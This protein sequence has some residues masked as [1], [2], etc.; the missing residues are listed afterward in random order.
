MD[1]YNAVRAITL[2]PLLSATASPSLTVAA[3]AAAAA[4][5]S[6]R[7]QTNPFTPAYVEELL[8]PRLLFS[9]IPGVS[10][11]V[12]CLLCDA[13]RLRHE[14]QR[15]QRSAKAD[16]GSSVSNT[17]TSAS[18]APP[19]SPRSTLESQQAMEHDD[20]AAGVAPLP[21]PPAR[22]GDVLRCIARVF[23]ELLPSFSS[24]SAS[25]SPST[26]AAP[27]PLKRIAYLIERAA[28]SH[29][30]RYLLPHCA[31]ASEDTQHALQSVFDA[32]RC[33][34]TSTNSSSSASAAGSAGGDHGSRA[35]SASNASAATCNEMAQL[36]T[37]IL[38]ATRDISSAQ[39]TPLLEELAGA[40]CTLR[41]P[42][43]TSS[44]WSTVS[45]RGVGGN[46]GSSTAL[47]GVLAANNDVRGPTQLRGGALV[48]ARVLMEQADVV[49]QPAVAAWAVSEFN[50]GV[51]EL[52]AAG[53]LQEEADVEDDS[54]K[55]ERDDALKDQEDKNRPPPQQQRQQRTRDTQLSRRGRG[56]R[57]VARVLEVVVA[58]TELSVDLVS[59]VLP[60]IA[61]HLELPND[62]LRL[63]LVRGFG[64]VFAAHDAA[65]STYTSI[66]TGPFLSRFL[67]VRP[68]IR[69]EALRV[70]SMLLAQCVVRSG[71]N[72]SE[73]VSADAYANCAAQQAQLWG[74]F[75]LCWS[76]SLTDPHVLVRKQA[77]CSV[78]EAAL[79]SPLLFQQ[80]QQAQTQSQPQPSTFLAQTVGL[81]TRDKNKRVRDTAVEGLT[82][83]YHAYQLSW[84]PNA[85]LDATRV[86]AGG[87]S[88]STSAGAGAGAAAVSTAVM[89]AE[90][91]VENLLPSPSA[92]PLPSNV[93]MD[94]CGKQE[95]L[96]RW[97]GSANASATRSSIG[98]AN[99]ALFDFELPGNYDRPRVKTEITTND[100]ERRTR[101]E[102]DALLG[103]APVAAT[104]EET[105]TTAAAAVVE[106][107][108]T[109]RSQ[110]AL[111]PA[112]PATATYVDGLLHLC[113][114]LDAAHFTQLLR[115]AE[116]KPQLRL[117]VQKLFEFHAAVKA[118]NGDVKSVEGQQRINAIHR[119]LRFLQDTTGAQRG[120]WDA[121]FRAKDD[122]VRRALLRACD[123]SHL[124]WVDVR[125][126]LLRSL[127]G[128]VSPDV[129]AFVKN[130]LVPQLLWP[131]R[132]DHLHELMRRLHR[133]IYVSDRA[134]VV[135]DTPE[136]VAVLRALLFLTA[137]APSY[138]V[139]SAAGLAEALQAAATQSTAPPPVWCALLL[140]ALQQWATAAASA[141]C[142]N[143]TNEKMRTLVAPE[144]RD[145]LVRALRAM[146]LAS[147]PM[148]RVAVKK[149]EAKRSSA[150]SS[151]ASSSSTTA[152]SSPLAS[153]KQLAKQ[154]TRTLLA[155]V[156]VAEFAQGA[157]AALQSLVA[158]L[159]HELT[160]GR[161]LTNDVKTVA[162]LA[163][164]QALSAHPRASSALRVA[165]AT[166]S[167][168][169]TSTSTSSSSSTPE[170][171]EAQLPP[172]LPHLDTLL[173]AAV[174]DVSD[175]AE[176]AKLPKPQTSTAPAAAS[177]GHQK[178]E[179]EAVMT[180]VMPPATYPSYPLTLTMS[181][182]A[183]IVDGTSKVMTRL[184]L[185]CPTA[186]GLRAAA[187]SAV[188][189]S[190]LQGYKAVAGLSCGRA[191]PSSI[192]SCQ[193]RLAVE[194]QLV[195][196][197]ATPT[198]AIAKE[199]AAAVV[200]SV[201]EEAQVREAVQ[202][203][204]ASLLLQRSCDMRVGALLLLTAIS[205]DTK[206]SYHR[207]RSLVESIGDHL[208]GRQASQG[209]SLS[210]PAALYCYWEYAIP[211]VVL[212]LAHHPY[213]ATEEAE[214]QFLNFQRVWH[215]L[216]GEL[217]RH[218]TQCAGFV[219]ELLSNIK[220]SDDA[221]DPSSNATRVMCDL[222]SRVLL[223]CLGQR[224]SRAEDLRRYP[225]AILLP[226]FFVKTAQSSPQK[227]LETVYLPDNV[228]VAPN[229]AFRLAPASTT[230][231]AGA[232][233]GGS[234]GSSRQATS[235]AP[236]LAALDDAP[237][238]TGRSSV[239][240]VQQQQQQRTPSTQRK[241]PRSPSVEVA[242]AVDSP[243]ASPS[244]SPSVTRRERSERAAASASPLPSSAPSSAS[245]SSSPQR[246]QTE[247]ALADSSATPL[248]S[249]AHATAAKEEEEVKMRRKAIQ[250]GAVD[251]ALKELFAGLTKPQ[252]AQLRWKVVRARLE[253]AIQ[254]AE[255]E[256]EAQQQLQQLQH[257]REGFVGQATLTKPPAVMVAEGNLEALLQY[258]KDQL[259]VWYNAAAA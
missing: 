186:N 243:A 73:H 109:R 33:A 241:R 204:L 15:Q 106:P 118:S 52:L 96:A 185:S 182:A 39:L 49:L 120:E 117:A 194:K 174:R 61:P 67:D 75:R 34:T 13:V 24:Y 177:S 217:F 105:A 127:R 188:L 116:K 55:E 9:A 130:A 225:G 86:E 171:A 138:H 178:E 76:R 40:S 68:A 179:E 163:S 210:S 7:H 192:A 91:V 30:F 257:R 239:V 62:D 250:K 143:G 23:A 161:A 57:K 21:F 176:Q 144:Q 170:S 205:E 4:A 80:P 26:V 214:M 16:S 104:T 148:Q 131:T 82:R 128:R 253:E 95:T 245:S 98:R 83:L 156:Q 93:H 259:R 246:S 133:C 248:S 230:G 27:L 180:A 102:G 51:E 103:F 252:I 215:L 218:G 187:V 209:V 142:P 222:G 99:L 237:A 193:R 220:R 235:R 72:N 90:A 54:D 197:L 79:T 112:A 48:T 78:I 165:A 153:L 149:N 3:A 126:V 60:T 166:G 100:E 139:L 233:L 145:A 234:R 141:S 129:F 228:R 184:A 147:L 84:I 74:A 85:V 115:L 11:L 64:A 199:M 140:Q 53:V 37:D 101:D 87:S 189:E 240:H 36:L 146:A 56:L 17:N 50:E 65:V 155:L 125:D 45:A 201:E 251:V 44:S 137:G 71:A 38:A 232:T 167:P 238:K 111:S 157:A 132:R 29:V 223:E 159:T 158:D 168:A 32:V 94:E 136:A 31:T 135:V 88:S 172:L 191:G 169:V 208:R 69:M 175:S 19:P 219:A 255:A 206:S 66:F 195:K 244:L 247:P 41:P 181:V 20:V 14:Q 256:F 25:S 216:I 152:T 242:V 59:Q 164:V 231:G 77:V 89:L 198:P 122:T 173:L 160:H 207:L 190:L 47:A 113:R 2:R 58:L 22:C 35:A 151:S 107:S 46:G 226:S 18:T 97:M 10:Q 28:V 63:L 81:R 229:A 1:A 203:K 8:T 123:S 114:S 221:L 200:L 124:D 258:A 121:L 134:E 110:H 108:P 92:T 12:A 212:F 183:A 42:S 213:Y 6:T 254:E 196:L 227:L 236:S 162:W 154:A 119:L 5:S 43:K 202:A 224:Q 211:F 70:S 150:A 249:S